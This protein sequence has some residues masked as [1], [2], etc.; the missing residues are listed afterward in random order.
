MDLQLGGD[1]FGDDLGSKAPRRLVRPPVEHGAV[2]HQGDLF[3][4]AEVQ[5]GPDGGL[6]PGPGPPGLVEHGGIGDLELGY[7]ERPAKAG[8]VVVEGE[9]AGHYGH[10][11]A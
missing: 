7:G 1:V 5:V 10:H 6:E 8:P 9:R 11:A 3:G 2:D 4:P